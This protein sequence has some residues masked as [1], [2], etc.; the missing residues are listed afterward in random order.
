MGFKISTF[1]ISLIV[2]GLFTGVFSL[3]I[4]YTNNEYGAKYNVTYDNTTLDIYNQIDTLRNQTEQIQNST[5][6][7]SVE[8]SGLFDIVG[9]MFS[10]GYKTVKLTFQSFGIFNKIA[11]K[12][13]E[14]SN[15]GI[16]ATLFKNA[17]I[18]IILVL[19]VIGFILAIVVKW[20]T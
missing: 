20:E 16:S 5:M 4:A 15:L 17:I 6:G 10:S 11:D 3:Y 14:D 18:L 1:I 2:V 19:I 12:A 9:A 8:Q 13:I 7:I